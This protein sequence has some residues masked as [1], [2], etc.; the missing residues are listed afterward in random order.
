GGVLGLLQARGGQRRP[1]RAGLLA[2]E[3]AQ[4]A[5]DRDD[6]DTPFGQEQ[7]R[8]AAE[9]LQV[10]GMGGHHDQPLHVVKCFDANAFHALSYLGSSGSGRTRSEGIRMEPQ[11]EYIK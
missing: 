3:V 2:A 4:G 7:D 10:V 1:Y 5:V 8:A 9:T 11:S 6:L